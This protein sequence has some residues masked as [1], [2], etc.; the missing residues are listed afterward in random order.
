V[1]TAGF[2]SESVR[3]TELSPIP[4]MLPRGGTKSEAN[5]ILILLFHFPKIEQPDRTQL[6]PEIKQK[7]E[8]KIQEKQGRS[9]FDVFSVDSRPDAY[10]FI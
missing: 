6:K 5:P 9:Y 4:A 3:G 2:D 7:Y 8:I 1:D 10:P